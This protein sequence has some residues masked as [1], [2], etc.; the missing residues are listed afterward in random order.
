[1]HTNK[2]VGKRILITGGAGFIGSHL[3]DILVA[4]PNTHVIAVDN[5]RLGK[6]ENIAHLMGKQNFNFFKTDLADSNSLQEILS[7]NSVDL[8]FHLAA[9]SDI[10]TSHNDPSTDFDNTFLVTWNLLLAMKEFK[11]K[12]LVFASTS[13]I[14]GQTGTEKINESYGPVEP[15]SHYGAA[16][17]ASEAFISSFSHNY[18]IDTLIVRFPN[19]VGSRST[20]GIIYD[21]LKKLKLNPQYLEVLG[22]GMQE[23]SY[24]HVED[25]VKAILFCLDIKQDEFDA[26]NV[27]GIDT[28]R[29][30]R[31]AEIILEETR[32]GQSINYTGGDRGWVG[33][34]PK[35]N[36]DISRLLATGWRPQMNSEQ[37]IRKTVI[38]LIKEV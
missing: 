9:N 31:I 20:H 18:G 22:N 23:K 21:L 25:L 15:I 34:V 14:Y 5:F 1:M 4:Q 16:K 6:I 26:F 32:T 11:I 38:S 7:V 13:A 19:V 37:A 12:S 17:L 29:V 27:G 33:D 8:V 36:Y 2:I 28:I 35:F 10:S 3:C 30:S 24:L